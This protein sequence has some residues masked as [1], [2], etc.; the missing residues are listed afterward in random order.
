MSDCPPKTD[1]SL[2]HCAP[3][4][5]TEEKWAHHMDNIEDCVFVD[6]DTVVMQCVPDSYEPSSCQ[7][8]QKPDV[9]RLPEVVVELEDFE[10]PGECFIKPPHDL[11]FCPDCNQSFCTIRSLYAHNCANRYPE[12][13]MKKSHQCDICFKFFNAPSKLKRHYVTHTG[14][15]AFQCTQCQKSFTQ[16]H[17]LKTHM[18]SHR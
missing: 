16:S 3:E 15:R 9:P 5:R 1:S 11:P 17:H 13:E 10:D 18:L 12:G 2:P 14:Q 8:Q 4:S 7:Y 6:S